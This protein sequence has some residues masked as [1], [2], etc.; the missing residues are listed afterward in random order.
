MNIPLLWES[1]SSSEKNREL[2]VLLKYIDDSRNKIFN[3]QSFLRPIITLKVQTFL[4]PKIDPKRNKISQNGHLEN[5]SFVCIS[6]LI[7]NITS[8]NG[9]ITLFIKKVFGKIELN[10]SFSVKVLV[11]VETRACLSPLAMKI[12]QFRL[13]LLN[14]TNILEM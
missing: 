9:K 5:Q 10:C 13:L 2:N 14:Q 3:Q 7:E 12:T 4:N 6:Y 8:Y 11:Y 1:L